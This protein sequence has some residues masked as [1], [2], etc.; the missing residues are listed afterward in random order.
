M[1]Q[2]CSAIKFEELVKTV[3]KASQSEAGG[4]LDLFVKKIVLEA[5]DVT[6]KHEVITVLK[7]NNS[8]K[9][10]LF[11]TKY[12]KDFPQKFHQFV[13]AEILE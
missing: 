10:S 3:C 13:F 8:E 12:V 11:I 2:T 5:A 9:L 1:C 7:E 6:N 4:K